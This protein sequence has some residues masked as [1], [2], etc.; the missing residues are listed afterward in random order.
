Y[1]V[2]KDLHWRATPQRCVGAC[3]VVEL[4]PAGQGCQPFVVA[5]VEAG[6]SPFPKQRLDEGFGFA[7]GLRPVAPSH[8][9]DSSDA[10]HSSLESRRERVAEAAVSHDSLN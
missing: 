6:V 7:I 4:E 5:D 2:D 3:V 9:V 1:L 8:L 10:G